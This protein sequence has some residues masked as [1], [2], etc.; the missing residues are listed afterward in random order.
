MFSLCNSQTNRV[1]MLNQLYV[2]W[3]KMRSDRTLRN[4][5]VYNIMLIQ[6]LHKRWIMR[7]LQPLYHE[8]TAG[9]CL[10]CRREPLVPVGYNN[11]IYDDCIFTL[12]LRLRYFLFYFYFFFSF[13]KNNNKKPN[14][15]AVRQL[16]LSIPPKIP[17]SLT[18]LLL[19]EYIFHL[20]FLW[21]MKCS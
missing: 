11:T 9:G 16:W 14:I 6:R 17:R 20:R 8:E 13:W 5:K 3:W 2:L 12:K 10:I 1:M 7:T 18:H 19:C 21:Q 4:I 15:Y